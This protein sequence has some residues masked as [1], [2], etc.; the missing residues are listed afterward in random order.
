M[1][2]HVAY[3]GEGVH[4]ICHRPALVLQALGRRPAEGARLFRRCCHVRS[5]GIVH[6]GETE[7]GDLNMTIGVDEDVELPHSEN[8]FSL[9]LMT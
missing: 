2:H 5:L 1:P 3:A 7:V 6:H 8:N 4:V 9:P